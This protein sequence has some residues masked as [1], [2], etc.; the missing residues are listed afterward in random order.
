MLKCLLMSE[1]APSQYR[2]SEA[3]SEQ[4]GPAPR[5]QS[6]IA[7][8]VGAGGYTGESLPNTAAADHLGELVLYHEYPDAQYKGE[9]ANTPAATSS[10]DPEAT[11]VTLSLDDTT[12]RVRPGRPGAMLAGAQTSGYDTRSITTPE[13][14]PSQP[15]GAQAGKAGRKKAP[16][17]SG[18]QRQQFLDIMSRFEEERA[19]STAARGGKPDHI[20]NL[21]AALRATRALEEAKHPWAGK[22][23]GYRDLGIA[24]LKSGDPRL[25]RVYSDAKAGIV[26]MMKTT[27][28]RGF[29]HRIRHLGKA[30]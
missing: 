17:L 4:F 24:P 2:P 5:D 14:T 15:S 29:I 30:A 8:A 9:I 1:A 6:I 26:P 27:G 7:N 28:V 13:P 25:L 19:A 22:D 10:P 20:E 21:N 11:V 12:T 3:P 18:A 23:F 16:A